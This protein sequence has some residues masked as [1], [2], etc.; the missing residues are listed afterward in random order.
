MSTVFRAG[1]AAQWGAGVWPAAPIVSHGTVAAVLCGLASGALPPYA[2]ALFALAVTGALLALPFL[3]DF[4]ALLR[5]DPAAEW[6]ETLPVSRFELRLARTLLILF[7]V[8]VLSLAALL[9]AALFAPDSAGWMGRILLIAAGLAQG[10]AI[11][12]LLVGLQ[13]ALGDRAEALLVL[14]QTLLFMGIALGLVVGLRWVPKMTH[15]EGPEGAWAGLAFLPPAWFAS[16]FAPPELAPLWPWRALPVLLVLASLVVLAACPLPHTARARS[17]GGWTST[18]L[19]P[20]R[21]LATR[22]W[23]KPGERASFDLVFDALPLER[24]FVLRTYPMVGIPLAFLL[25]GSG[26]DP[27]PAREG[28]L[29][30][31]LFMPVAYLPILLVH[32]PASASHEARWILDTAPHPRA[33][34]AGGAIK[35]VAVRFLAPLYVALFLLAWSQAGLGFALR[36][37]IPAAIFAVILL[38]QLYTMFVNENPL[39]VAPDEIEAKIDWAGVLAGLGIGSTLIA[40]LASQFVTSLV[41]GLVVTAVLLGVERLLDRQ[42]ASAPE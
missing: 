21:G 36:L 9:P 34:H 38:R 11:V 4:G 18:L 24:E 25:A 39:S 17:T 12:A 22:V 20:L 31:L 16:F 10:L 19:A 29:A 35:A 32:V 33:T 15:L 41:A 1:F 2:Y 42:P 37:G 30:V 26:A 6:V 5:S 40:I 8:A 3:G 7:S 23:L 13:S 28:L 27:G 14:L